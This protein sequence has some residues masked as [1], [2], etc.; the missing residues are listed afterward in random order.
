MTLVLG[1]EDCWESKRKHSFGA[2]TMSNNMAT[3]QLQV[4][5]SP[6]WGLDCF[7]GFACGGIFLDT[8]VFLPRGLKLHWQHFGCWGKTTEEGSLSQ[9]SETVCLVALYPN[10]G[11]VQYFSVSH[12]GI[13]EVSCSW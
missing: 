7:R 13:T 1:H 11:E 4:S 3:C 12:C 8:H 9:V 6:F 10:S 5:S 2:L